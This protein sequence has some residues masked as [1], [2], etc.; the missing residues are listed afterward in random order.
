MGGATA[1]FA[2]KW[3]GLFG[4]RILHPCDIHLIKKHYILSIC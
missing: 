4:A 3:P 2:A 1:A